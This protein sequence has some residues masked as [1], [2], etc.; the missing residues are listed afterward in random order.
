M[1]KYILSWII[2]IFACLAFADGKKEFKKIVDN[3]N[4]EEFLNANNH[5]YELQ[6]QGR[7]YVSQGKYKKALECYQKALVEAEKLFGKNSTAVASSYTAMAVPYIKL[8]GNLKAADSLVK[9]YEIFSKSAGK[10][11]RPRAARLVL[12]QAGFLY[13][14]SQCY[15]MAYQTLEQAQSELKSFSTEEKEK[16]LPKFN[17]YLGLAYLRE[18]VPWKAIPYLQKSLNHENKNIP[19]DAAKLAIFNLFLGEAFLENSEFKKALKYLM[20]S[21]KVSKSIKIGVP[22][23]Y[24]LY[25]CLARTFKYLN[26][27]KEYYKFAEKA[28]KAANLFDDSDGRKIVAITCYA[29]ASY[30][31]G[32]ITQAK[33]EL[34]KARI[35]AKRKSLPEKLR[36]RINNLNNLW[37]TK[38]KSSNKAEIAYW[39]GR[40]FFDEKML[41]NAFASLQQALKDEKQKT[42]KNYQLLSKI[43]FWLGKISFRFGKWKD[44][45]SYSN[46]SFANIKQFKVVP[47]FQLKLFSLL[48]NSYLMLKEYEQ[49]LKF[50]LKAYDIQRVKYG[51]DNI[52][53]G[54][55]AFGIGVRYNKLNQK[56]KALKYLNQALQ[57]LNK[58]EKEYPYPVAVTKKYISEVKR[59]NK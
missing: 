58:F 33:N 27:Q 54:I 4:S 12:M 14:E 39:K 34:N 23:K 40:V 5:V 9:S 19:V 59:L 15:R 1:K 41:D 57:I 48:S 42:K 18:G 2:T 30:N 25:N 28:F 24:L 43:N 31:V 38:A 36:A 6:E 20:E 32:R 7:Q 47:D 46:K 22:H 55:I 8:G 56:E 29:D 3:I 50:D 26:E 44:A 51:Q 21:K 37:Q 45:I 11:V 35:L 49:A 10:L 13:F 16:Y 17:K 52:R 53:T